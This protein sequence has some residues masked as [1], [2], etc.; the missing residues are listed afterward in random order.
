MCELLV[1]A[2]VWLAIAAY[3]AGL[4]AAW[5]GRDDLDFQRLSRRVYSLGCAAF[6]V[7]VAAAFHVY[8]GWSHAR[9]LAETARQTA[10]LTGTESGLGLWANY[11]FT[12]FW[13]LDVA[14]WWRSGLRGHRQRPAWIGVGLHSFFLFMIF[15]ATVVFEEGPARWAGAALFLTLAGLGFVAAR[16]R[17]GPSATS[18]RVLR[19]K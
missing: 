2:S 5:F 14:S 11:F 1:R 9:A 15:N 17:Y 6:L 3:P 10:E 13:A 16:R 7:H 4:L 18:I 8:H 12:L 19:K